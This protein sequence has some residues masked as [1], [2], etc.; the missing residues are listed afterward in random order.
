[1]MRPVVA[2]KRRAARLN[3]PNRVGPTTTARLAAL[4]SSVVSLLLE[5]RYVLHQPSQRTR[6]R[7][8]SS[9]FAPAG[10]PSAPMGDRR[11][12]RVVP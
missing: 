12:L 1:M 9:R 4:Q 6:F 10:T 5:M 2:F 3:Q 7:L 8:A 11:A